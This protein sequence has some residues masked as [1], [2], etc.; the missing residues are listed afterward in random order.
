LKWFLLNLTH[1]LDELLRSLAFSVAWMFA[2]GQQLVHNNA[3]WPDVHFFGVVV[4][5]N[6]FGR[7]VNQSACF[8]FSIFTKP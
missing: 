4:K 5:G 8:L 6:L 1:F 3:A 2:A 7:H